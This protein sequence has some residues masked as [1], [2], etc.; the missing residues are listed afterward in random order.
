MVKIVFDTYAWIE[1]FEGSKK[2]EIAK[3]YLENSEVLTPVVVLLEL[4][5][6]FEKEGG[7]FKKHLNFIKLNSKIVGFNDDFVLSFGKI[8]NKMKKKIRDFG[9]ADAIVLNTAEIYNANVLTG[10]KHFSNI[11]GVILLE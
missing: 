9:L 6:K 4:S 3:E 10:D 8:Y 2:G 5:Y 1:Y 11:N 7:D